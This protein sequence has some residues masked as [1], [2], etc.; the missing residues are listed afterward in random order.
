MS[1]HC[2]A[3]ETWGSLMTTELRN[4]LNKAIHREGFGGAWDQ[5]ELEDL[6]SE[7]EM[8]ERTWVPNLYAVVMPSAS[9]KSTY[10]KVQ[11]CI[12]IDEILSDTDLERKLVNERYK[13]MEMGPRADWRKH[14]RIWCTEVKRSLDQMEFEEPTIIF[15]HTTALAVRIG[16]TPILTLY[17]TPE[18]HAVMMKSRTPVGKKLAVQ[19]RET[20]ANGV[21][22]TRYVEFDT[23]EKRLASLAMIVPKYCKVPV[24]LLGLSAQVADQVRD[25]TEV[26][27]YLDCAPTDLLRGK[28]DTTKLDE[29]EA[30][31]EVGVIP[32]CCLRYNISKFTGL[33]Y[34]GLGCDNIRWMRLG[35][36]AIEHQRLGRDKFDF[37]K[38]DEIDWQEVYPYDSVRERNSSNVGMKRML[39]FLIP[40]PGSYIEH[41]LN[42]SR[43]IWHNLIVSTLIYWAGVV[44]RMRPELV[45]AIVRSK[46]LTVDMSNFLAITKEMHNLVRSTGTFFGITITAEEKSE[47]MYWHNLAGRHTYTVDPIPEIK[48]RSN[49]LNNTKEA[50][51]GMSWTK[52]SYNKYVRDGVQDAYAK[53]G[54]TRRLRHELENFG[55]FWKQRAAWGASGSVVRNNY[56][57]RSYR[58]KV[59]VTNMLGKLADEVTERHNKRT[60]F[61]DP[62][63]LGC[64]IDD[65]VNNIGRNDSDAAAKFN[66]AGRGERVLFPG[67]LAHYIV[68]SIILYAFEG[69]ADIG[70]T[71][72]Y[73]EEDF[74]VFD[75]FLDDSIKLSYDFASFNEYHSIDDMSLVMS[76]LKAFLSQ[77]DDLVLF[78]LNWVTLSFRKME[79]VDVEGNKHHLSSGLFSGWRSTSWINTVLN[80]AYFYVV[81][82]CCINL[83]GY[84]PIRHYDGF[85]DDV[86]MMLKS[87]SDAARVYAVA[88]RIGYEANLL[89][90]LLGRKAEFLRV[91]IGGTVAHV[92]ICRVLGNYVSGSMEG[93][94]A[95]LSERV[96]T[97]VNG[98]HQLRHRGLDDSVCQHVYSAALGHVAKIKIGGEWKRPTDV[99]LHTRRSQGGLGVPDRD[100]CV[101]VLK[102]DLKRPDKIGMSYELPFTS[103]TDDMMESMERELYTKGLSIARK[104]E[105]RDKIAAASFNVKR[106]AEAISAELQ[107]EEWEAYWM[108][109]GE[110]VEKVQP[111]KG[112]ISYSA[113]SSFFS[114][115]QDSGK[116][117]GP[118]ADLD[119]ASRYRQYVGHVVNKD[120]KLL[121]Y[122][123]MAE[124]VTGRGYD[125]ESADEFDARLRNDEMV[126]GFARSEIAKYITY[127]ILLCDYTH[128]GREW[129]RYAEQEYH[130]IIATYCHVFPEI[131]ID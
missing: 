22:M 83:F 23:H 2:E 21:K 20:V 52:Y 35:R 12:D 86:A 114:W 130:N 50:F 26:T 71:R 55:E 82:Q 62:A 129:S 109:I 41:V 51:N 34:D 53:M 30:L 58:L 64:M 108:Q 106:A 76:E 116:K 91:A 79:I 75:S 47:L 56:S 95:P 27:G 131:R 89:K 60:L 88:D 28:W 115:E 36:K 31:A 15:V 119:R 11:G 103:A 43:G 87:V 127:K 112:E 10:C 39:A 113:L 96:A 59:Y 124:Y 85:G 25:R 101:W 16:A 107:A 9:G 48:K 4:S 77:S 63:V 99:V 3:D 118:L 49:D 19:N 104:G 125:F 69:I 29:V 78:A 123:E 13:L 45:E 42:V 44:E 84:D 68:T 66:E 54:S 111:P 6:I 33:E 94:A 97:V 98:T 102:S 92:C 80:H 90:Q 24:P 93:R 81:R 17:A 14:N 37:T 121:S 122:Q 32:D 73:V 65:I 126:P 7:Y 74:R 18:L 67:N 40:K 61:E 57:E 5:R 110:V 72:L 1:S 70:S 128:Y 105:L 46:L 120:D 8:G 38:S 100:G 117:L